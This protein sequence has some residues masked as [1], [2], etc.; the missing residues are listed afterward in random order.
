VPRKWLS[1]GLETS[2]ATRD[3]CLRR[4]GS[5]RTEP[6]VR[7]KRQAIRQRRDRRG[8][9]LYTSEPV[10]HEVAALDLSHCSWPWASFQGTF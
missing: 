4:E 8:I 7:K 5:A 1:S 6:Y 2:S 3:A 9:Q 10:L